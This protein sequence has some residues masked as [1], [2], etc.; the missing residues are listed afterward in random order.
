MQRFTI[1][2]RW[3]TMLAICLIIGGCSISSDDPNN[4]DNSINTVQPVDPNGQQPAPPATDFDP[5]TITQI[6]FSER[7]AEEGVVY[8]DEEIQLNIEASSNSDTPSFTLPAEDVQYETSQPDWLSIA[9]TG[10]LLVSEDAPIGESAELIAHYGEFSTSTQV[11][12]K[13]SLEET[14]LPASTSG[15]PVV[16]NPDNPAVIVNKQ[17][18]L[19]DD[20]EPSDLVEPNVPFSFDEWDEKRQLRQVAAEAL[21]SL[22][23]Q[24]EEDDITLRA[25][26][27]YRS[28]ARQNY[29]FNMYIETQGEEH[30]RRFSAVPGT[31]EHQT[32]LTMDVSAPSVGYALD[33]SFG[34]TKEG[35]WLA[36]NAHKHGFIIR[37]P[38]EKE[39]LTGYAYEPWHI[40]YVGKSIATEVYEQDIILEQYFGEAVPVT[41][42]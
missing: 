40:R 28:Y 4:N 32:G 6:Q 41:N 39:D 1:Y 22:F 30:A 7:I 27:G 14:L 17:R 29:L 35:I 10:T 31:S 5:K 8:P 21:E 15:I 37:Y 19:P 36:E 42:D 33:Q 12:V 20:Y 11:T 13:Y 26:S 23:A 3:I 2:T 18:S 34:D 9:A 16:T 25:V 24:A 38:Q